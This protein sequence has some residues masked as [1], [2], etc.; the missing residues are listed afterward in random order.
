MVFS[1][2][3]IISLTMYTLNAIIYHR[4]R[5]CS[6]SRGLSRKREKWGEKNGAY[7]VLWL[8]KVIMMPVD[9]KN[10]ESLNYRNF[11]RMHRVMP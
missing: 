10:V 2:S 7:N 1:Y 5:D 8:D 4:I 3:T 6:F 9:W 11:Q